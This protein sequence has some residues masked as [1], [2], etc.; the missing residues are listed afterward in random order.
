V[1]PCRGC[2][3]C[4]IGPGHGCPLA[5]DAAEF[6]F[7]A[8]GEASV[9]A[10][11]SPVYFY[12]LPAL[13]K[14]LIDRAQRHYEL[15]LA[16]Q[17]AGEAAPAERVAEVLLVAGRR[18]GQQLFTGSLLT[19]RYF[20]WSFYARPVEN[21]CLLRGFDAPDDLASD[22]AAVEALVARGLAAAGLSRTSPAGGDRE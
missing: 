4:A 18:E 9:L 7:D 6:L 12:H 8:I 22:S 17:A 15:R 3:V 16:R 13:F 19:L 2:G 1:R 20:L 5:G 10:F 11:A 21:P 14:A